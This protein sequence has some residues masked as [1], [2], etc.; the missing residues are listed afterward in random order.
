MAEPE[1]DPQ[2]EQDEKDIQAIIRP[3]TDK[4]VADLEARF[5]KQ[6]YDVALLVNARVVKPGADKPEGPQHAVQFF[7]GS[8]TDLIEV[9]GVFRDALIRE[10]NTRQVMHQLNLPLPGMVM[11]QPGEPPNPFR[12]TPKAPKPK[13]SHRRRR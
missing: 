6:R 10:Q 7:H 3:L 8:L 1:V 11:P 5:G 4:V 9:L 2:Y 13:N 12:P